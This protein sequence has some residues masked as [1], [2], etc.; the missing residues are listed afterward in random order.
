MKYGNLKKAIEIFDDYLEDDDY[1]L[2][3]HGHEMVVF[4]IEP[5][6][7]SDEDKEQLDLIDVYEHSDGYFYAWA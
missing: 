7:V 4:L 1:I 6:V 2:D 5:E 3:G